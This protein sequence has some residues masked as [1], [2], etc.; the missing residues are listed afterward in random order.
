MLALL[1]RLL[2][3]PAS[4]L[5]VLKMFVFW[6]SDNPFNMGGGITATRMYTMFYDLV[7]TLMQDGEYLIA[8]LM[9]E[10]MLYAPFF[11]EARD[12]DRAGPNVVQHRID[13]LLPLVKLR[14][15]KYAEAAKILVRTLDGR[16]T[17]D[18]VTAFLLEWTVQ[19][20]VRLGENVTE[21]VRTAYNRVREV[22]TNQTNQ[23]VNR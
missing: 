17:H 6:D 12:A 16:Y 3:P 22:Y 7:P 20:M 14:L 8:E 1:V 2:P 4:Y 15:H 11:A 18:Y 10:Q 5:S 9:F 13:N 21:V 19:Q 23:G